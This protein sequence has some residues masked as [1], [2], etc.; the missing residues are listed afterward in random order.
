MDFFILAILVAIGIFVLNGQD[1]RRRIALLGSHL[2]QYQIEKLMEALTQGY[3]RALGEKD[4]ERRT[5][6]WNLLSTTETQLCEQ[7]SRFATSFARV[8]AEE[9]RVSKIAFA[10]P[11]IDKL[12]PQATFDLRQAFA[13]HAKGMADTV[14]N[15]AQR[16]PKDKA[17]T[18]SAELFLMQHTCHWFCK[19]KVVASARMLARHQTA[20][21][22]L[23]E[24]VSP[25]TRKAYSSL[26]E[27]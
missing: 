21:A 8:P 23:L 17:F 16:S 7:F 13:I 2:S 9:T 26:I 6:I 1:Q 4:E 18:M 22:Q 11:Y 12:L 5:Q 24:A 14:Q 27:S 3:L 10:I 25:G 20:Y 15:T 19:S